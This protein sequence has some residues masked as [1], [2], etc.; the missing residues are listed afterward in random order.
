MSQLV[1]P[2]T[3]DAGTEIVAVEHQANYTAI[4]DLING[5]L[6]GGAG[7][8]LKAKGVT[9]REMDNDLLWVLG[10]TSKWVEGIVSPLSLAVSPGAGL[11]LN[12]ANGQAAIYDDAG[13]VGYPGHLV[14]VSLASGGTVT[15]AANVSGN[16][17]IDQIVLTLSAFGTGGATVSVLQGTP[18]GG[19]TLANRAG[20]A[21]LPSGVMRLADVL[22]PNGFGGP[23]G[24]TGYIR[25]R[26]AFARGGIYVIAPTSDV[27]P[28]GGAFQYPANSSTPVFEVGV[29]QHLE[30]DGVVGLA[31]NAPGD[32]TGAIDLL[33]QAGAH[34]YGTSVQKGRAYIAGITGT[35]ILPIY[36]NYNTIAAGSYQVSLFGVSSP[37]GS[38]TLY[39]GSSQVTVRIVNNTW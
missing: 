8:N 23:F 25:D 5:N 38:G 29:N 33:D 16:P 18:T 24:A 9:A 37:G 34:T 32:T 10:P 22:M 36:W 20:A 12:Y 6:E 26:R 19:A 17:R 4:R 27:G 15:V 21:A 31:N 28:L 1:L 39:G 11:Q 7:N 13:I 35:L 2:H 30:I 14:V 3:I